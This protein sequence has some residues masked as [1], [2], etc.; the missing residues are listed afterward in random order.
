MLSS[1]FMAVH[2]QFEHD[3]P[4]LKWKVFRQYRVSPYEGLLK[5]KL[6]QILTRQVAPRTTEKIY[7]LMAK[8]DDDI[9]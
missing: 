3:Y 7:L 5:L 1:T 4:H 2:S 6:R 9:F 8:T